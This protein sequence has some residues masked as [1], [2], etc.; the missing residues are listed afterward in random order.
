MRLLTLL[1]I[2]GIGAALSA[3]GLHRGGRAAKA[4]ALVGVVALLGITV[5]AFLL[6]PGAV[7]ENGVPITGAFDAHLVA[8]AY[9]RLI[10]G[11]WGLESVVL[12]LVGWLLGGLLRLRGLLP[13][14]LAA[15]TG[16]TVALAAAD[17]S[18]G[19]AAGAATGLAALV[20]SLHGEGAAAVAAA[21][22]DLRVSLAGGAVLLGC[23]AVVPI[24]G[25]L[26][27]SGAG[28]DAGVATGASIGVPAM[29]VVAV[30]TTLVVAAR[31]GLLPFHVRVSRLADLVPP[32]TLPL[33]L[34]WLAVPLTV[35]AIAMVDRLVTPL[36]LPLDGERALLVVVALGS[37]VGGALA[38]FFH[39]D[40]R[41]AVAYVVVAEAGL[42]ILAIAAF[43]P[44]A[45][46]AG[47][48]WVVVLAASKTALLVWSAVTEDRFGTRSVPDLRGW[49]RRSPLLAVGLVLTAVATIG[50]PGWI[51]YD[52]RTTL[53][54]LGAA[55]PWDLLLVIGS[56]L[57]LPVYGR[58]LVVGVGQPTSRVDRAAPEWVA[59]A[60]RTWRIPRPGPPSASD[61][62]LPVLLEGQEDPVAAP[63]RVRTAPSATVAT[64]LRVVGNG[65]VKAAQ[66]DKT[67]LLSAAVLALAILAVLTSVGVLDLASAAAEPA[68][69]LNSAGTD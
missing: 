16:G 39:D 59:P 13:A 41:H 34:A 40:L 60:G 33:V 52:A 2:G 5:A 65:V 48:S 36:A 45:W 15:M 64:R 32:E 3:W 67:Q 27:L 21:A 50:L 37:M 8:S 14:T 66:R 61:E 30:V 69:I 9:L 4:G 35:V 31:W 55:P 46:G 49:I 10:V 28:S 6:R 20:I 42:L 25:R 18:V 38:A 51:A 43:D 11:L 26:A 62:R 29:G 7:D 63:S 44:A 57:T 47:R 19:F 24:A 68:P 1:L 12:I 53:A 23:L 58:L 17:L 54:S 22:R 56:V